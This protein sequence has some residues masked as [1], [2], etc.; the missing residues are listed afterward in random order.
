[1]A[2]GEVLKRARERK[3]LTQ[4][5]LAEKLYVDPSL[6][7]RWEKGQKKVPLVTLVQIA[8]IL[9]LSLD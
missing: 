1:M 7:C 9:E 8:E 2:I 4:R 6:V 5:Q 3:G